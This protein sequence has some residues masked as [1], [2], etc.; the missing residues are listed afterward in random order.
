MLGPKSHPSAANPNV[1]SPSVT[2][3]SRGIWPTT[4]SAAP[5]LRKVA[6]SVPPAAPEVTLQTS[7][8]LLR[9]LRRRKKVFQSRA[10]TSG[11]AACCCADAAAEDAASCCAAEVEADRLVTRGRERVLVGTE[12]KGFSRGVER[13][14]KGV[15]VEAVEYGQAALR[16]RTGWRPQ[17]AMLPRSIVDVDSVSIVGGCD[18]DLELVLDCCVPATTE[19]WYRSSSF[20]GSQRLCA[21][22]NALAIDETRDSRRATTPP[23]WT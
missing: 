17:R 5:E 6:P 8:H 4:A 23:V 7:C 18:N 9:T 2:S 13:I 3:G 20:G 16:R 21:L 14:P 11:W 22:R 12:A 1:M 19:L 15:G 10:G